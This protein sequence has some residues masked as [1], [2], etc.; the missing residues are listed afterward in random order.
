M[1]IKKGDRLILTTG[2]REIAVQAASDELDGS[3][4]VKQVTGAF[5]TC[6]RHDLRS[7]PDGHKP[8]S[9]SVP[10]T[11]NHPD[12]SEMSLRCPEC[13]K[14]GQFIPPNWVGPGRMLHADFIC[15]EGHEWTQNFPVR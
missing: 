10:I 2:G 3:V 1:G 8:S 9:D 5:A 7:D 12:P 13:G 4:V 6:S 11:G 15:P 14:A